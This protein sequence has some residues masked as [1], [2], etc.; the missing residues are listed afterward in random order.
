MA[1]RWVMGPHVPHWLLGIAALPRN[2]T[3]V[4]LKQL[5]AQ[6]P[7]PKKKGMSRIWEDPGI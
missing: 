3:G 2:L 4:M 6:P 5:V 1:T 7:F